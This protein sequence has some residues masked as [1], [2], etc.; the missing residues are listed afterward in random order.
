[1]P[2]ANSPNDPDG[3]IAAGEYRLCVKSDYHTDLCVTPT[4]YNIT[5]AEDSTNS[6]CNDAIALNTYCPTCENIN[7]DDLTMIL[8]PAVIG[9][10]LLT[11]VLLYY[12]GKA[13]LFGTKIATLL[14]KKKG[15]LNTSGVTMEDTIDGGVEL[16]NI[17]EVQMR[18][19]IARLKDELATLKTQHEKV[20]MT[21]DEPHAHRPHH[22]R[23]KR[24]QFG[25]TQTATTHQ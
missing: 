14:T 16:T 9:G 2:Y 25:E 8:V 20:T 5:I 17:N 21:Q 4:G 15:N 22:Q 1:M 23:K 11:G 13:G 24:I 7:S 19:E 18:T 12:G 6:Q 3:A 10:L